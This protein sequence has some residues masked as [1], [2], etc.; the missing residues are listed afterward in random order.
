MLMILSQSL[1]IHCLPSSCTSVY[2]GDLECPSSILAF[3]KNCSSNY[4]YTIFPASKLSWKSQPANWPA[5]LPPQSPPTILRC[6]SQL[7]ISFWK[8]S[9]QHIQGL[10]SSSPLSRGPRMTLSH[11]W[12]S[13]WL[14]LSQCQHSCLPAWIPVCNETL[15]TV[16]MGWVSMRLCLHSD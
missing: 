10:H 9:A 14:L 2:K 11:P 5:C 1:F 16:L 13:V 15:A 7:L 12:A 6:S 3:T 4:S 8:R